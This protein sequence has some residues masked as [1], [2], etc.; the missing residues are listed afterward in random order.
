MRFESRFERF[1]PDPGPP[2]SG[3][4]ALLDFGS[5]LVDQALV[6]F[7]SARS[8]YAE[9]HTREDRQPLTTTSSSQ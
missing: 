6:L 9:M 4:G 1:A 5:H 7:G 2:A 8:V 3:G